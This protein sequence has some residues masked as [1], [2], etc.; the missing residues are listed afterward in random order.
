MLLTEDGLSWGDGYY[1]S[2]LNVFQF[3]AIGEIYSLCLPQIF[4]TFNFSLAAY[5]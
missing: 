4:L 1:G 5:G 2:R 3:T